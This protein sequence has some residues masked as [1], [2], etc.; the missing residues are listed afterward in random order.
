MPSERTRALSDVL[1]QLESVAGGESIRVGEVVEH[2]GRKSFASL[3]LVF[4]LISTSPAS[5]IPGIT[6]TVAFLVFILAVQLIIGRKCVWLPGFVVR[7]S[8]STA[9]LCKGVGWLRKPVHFVERFLRPRFTFLLHRPWILLPLVLILALTMVMPLL[10]AIPT[11]GS[12]A[13]AVIALFAAALLTRDGALVLVSLALLLA[14]PVAV[15]Q[16]GPS[17]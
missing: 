12:I 11:S 2:L 13:S 1:D 3:M 15:W 10:E 8:M 17:I 7:R 9:K 6:A 5:G 14:L 4:A 16:F